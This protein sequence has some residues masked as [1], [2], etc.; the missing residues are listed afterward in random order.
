MGRALNKVHQEGMSSI[1]VR[2]NSIKR[3]GKIGVEMR[4]MLQLL[5]TR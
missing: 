4:E 2:K 1:S 3:S 5:I